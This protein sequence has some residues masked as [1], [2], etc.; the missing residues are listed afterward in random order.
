[1]KDVMSFLILMLLAASCQSTRNLSGKS[2][3]RYDIAYNVHLPDTT[4]DDWE[5]ITMGPDGSSKKNI[6]NNKDVAWTYHAYRDRLF[7][8]SDRDSC[9]RC[10]YLYES[11]VL[12]GH[13]R[14]ISNLQLEDS[15]MSTRKN[16]EEMIV[17]GRIGKTL[18]FQ[19][20]IVNTKSG[21]YR[22][23][24]NDTAAMFRDPCFSPDCKT[25]VLSYKA[26]KRDRST[27]EEL[28]TMKAD[29]SGLKQL[30]RY[31]ENNSSAKDYGYKAGSARWH[32]TDNFISYVSKQDGRN[33]I[34]AITPD[35][36]RQWK[37][38]DNP[39]ADGWHDW[40]ADGRW[41][42]YN[43]SD[44]EEKQYQVVLMN[45]KTREQKLL[46]D[47]QPPSPLGPVFVQR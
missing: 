21:A 30:T 26:N 28:Y 44:A 24:I 9:Y 46:T 39:D 11:D 37:L 7:F 45:W 42:V 12:G 31:P 29:G 3:A 40:S 8:I 23:I 47:N 25:I 20:F 1:M 43:K 17:S 33:S 13:V 19:L 18:R 10:F 34:F 27:H 5:I 35:G 38:L 14:K 4:K 16:G 15:W 36:K 22:Q 41:L 2:A 32:P 6:T